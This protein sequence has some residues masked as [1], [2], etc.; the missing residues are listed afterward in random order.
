M[1]HLDLIDAGE[2]ILNGVLGGDDLAIWAV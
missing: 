2:V 1:P